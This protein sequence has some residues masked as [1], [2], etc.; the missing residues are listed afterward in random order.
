MVLI[1]VIIKLILLIRLVVFISLVLVLIVLV[2]CVALI[3]LVRRILILL[4]L[5]VTIILICLVLVLISLIL[6]VFLVSRLLLIR[7]LILL[8]II[9][10]RCSQL[11]LNWW[12]LSLLRFL[13][14]F[15]NRSIRIH[16]LHVHKNRHSFRIEDAIYLQVLCQQWVQ[17]R[18]FLLNQFDHHLI[19]HFSRCLDLFLCTLHSFNDHWIIRI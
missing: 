9:L 15:P 10:G 6:S 14:P 4:L 17:H 7:L 1:V 2:I 13:W 3:V 5:V 16:V 12:L 8:S 11:I 18:K 19:D